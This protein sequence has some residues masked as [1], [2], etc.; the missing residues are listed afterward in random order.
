[1]I[2]V[3]SISE[4]FYVTFI[5]YV[6]ISGFNIT[7]LYSLKAAIKNHCQRLLKKTMSYYAR[8]GNKPTYGIFHTFC[9]F[10]F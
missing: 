4:I 7:S 3:N 8:G 9:G 6:H 10:Y 2:L 1:M 5:L